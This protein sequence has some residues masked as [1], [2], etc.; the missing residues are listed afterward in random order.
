MM[1]YQLTDGSYVTVDPAQVASVEET[2][3]NK[4][5]KTE[6]IAVIVLANGIRYTTLDPHRTVTSN[7]WKAK[8]ITK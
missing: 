7:L 4:A 6:N 5:G 1:R 8:E 2:I 3:Q